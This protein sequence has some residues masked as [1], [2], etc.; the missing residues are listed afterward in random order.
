M[1]N[2]ASPKVKS[3]PA[4]TVEAEEVKQSQ[5]NL[6]GM[7][8]NPTDDI[9]NGLKINFN[10]WGI[11]SARDI[12]NFLPL[13]DFLLKE[14]GGTKGFLQRSPPLLVEASAKLEEL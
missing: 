10:E 6:N 3:A 11:H 9:A 8:F 12:R 14:D 4:I 1:A 5:E 2:Q 13:Q 7:K